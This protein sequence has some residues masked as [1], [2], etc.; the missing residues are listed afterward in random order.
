LQI[1]DVPNAI[2]DRSSVAKA[3][4]FDLSMEVAKS[5]DQTPFT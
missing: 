3:K 2:F 4:I 1:V 5:D